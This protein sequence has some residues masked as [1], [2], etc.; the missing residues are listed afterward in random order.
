MRKQGMVLFS[1]LLMAH[2]AM[3]ESA[4]IESARYTSVQ[5]VLKAEQLE[6]LMAPVRAFTLPESL[7]T[8][9][10]AIELL[11]QDSGYTLARTAAPDPYAYILYEAPLAQVHRRIEHLRLLDVL[12]MLGSPGYTLETHP[13]SRTVWYRLS[14]EAKGQVDA[15]LRLLMQ[16]KQQAYLSRHSTPRPVVHKVLP[17]ETLAGIVAERNGW[18]VADLYRLYPAMVATYRKNPTA[19]IKDNLNL[20]KTNVFLNLP[21][22]AEIKAVSFQDALKIMDQ[23]K[24]AFSALEKNHEAAL[25]ARKQS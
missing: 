16:Q 5:P 14:D 10:E 4:P 2:Q 8:I 21:T 13:V 7:Q 6:P 17:G 19:F 25:D 24:Q 1:C 12:N 20:I 11:L 18:R 22:Q 23:H 9:G 3:G 15:E